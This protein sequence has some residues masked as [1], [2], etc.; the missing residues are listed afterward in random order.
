MTGVVGEIA[1][2][3]LAKSVGSFAPADAAGRVIE[4]NLVSF[5]AVSR[6]VLKVPR[7]PE[8]GETMR[9]GATTKIAGF[10]LPYSDGSK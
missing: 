6:R 4:I 1:A 9:H 3:E 5:G 10:L 2:M 7:C 8:C